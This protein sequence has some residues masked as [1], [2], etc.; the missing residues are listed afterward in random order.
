MRRSL[1][2]ALLLLSSACVK[3]ISSEDRLDRELGTVD[4][5]RAMSADELKKISC[6]DVSGEV[7]KAQNENRPETDRVMS[8]IELYDS[9]KKKVSSFEDAMSR[10][11]DLIYQSDSSQLVASRDVCVNQLAEV[12][13]GFE[14]YT[15]ELVEVGTLQEIRGGTTV[16]VPR[17]DFNT[18]RQA[19]NTLNPDDKDQL[20]ARVASQEKRV[21]AE[22]P[23]TGKRGSR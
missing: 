15:R 16:T 1:V 10:N 22:K 2:A 8:Y 11:P 3:E 23:A 12:R 18:L 9:L 7:E 4:D 14:R 19:I 20:L 17:M 6:A 13:Q 21:D 5:K